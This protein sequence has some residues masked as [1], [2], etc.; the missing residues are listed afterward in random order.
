MPVHNFAVLHSTSFAKVLDS[1]E[2]H[3]KLVSLLLKSQSLV[4]PVRR[5]VLK[6][7]VADE[8][9]AISRPG[10]HNGLFNKLFANAFIPIVRIHEYILQK[11]EGFLMQLVGQNIQK[12]PTNDLA[13]FLGRNFYGERLFLDIG[14]DLHFKPRPKLI[15]RACPDSAASNSVSAR[16][17]NFSRRYCR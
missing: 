15:L 16:P 5:F 3:P 14:L 2:I 17:P 6:S 7:A 8:L 1:L 11:A 12:S 9:V 4:K 13:P 10:F